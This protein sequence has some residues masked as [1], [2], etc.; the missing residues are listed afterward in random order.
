MSV[1]LKKMEF[2][3]SQLE[4][5]ITEKGNTG[6]LKGSWKEIDI[7]ETHVVS[8]TYQPT[9]DTTYIELLVFVTDVSIGDD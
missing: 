6:V 8:S 1:D 2:L 7:L 9:R 4:K 3:D 5:I